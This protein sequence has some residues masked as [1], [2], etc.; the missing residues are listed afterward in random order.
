[1]NQ[2]PKISVIVPIYKAEK[3]LNRCIDSLL[4]QTFS[5]FELLLIDDGSPDK[6]GDICDVYAE[7]DSRVR[8][9]HKKNGGVS[10]ARQCGLDNAIGEYV[11]HADPDD[12]VEKDMLASM[13]SKAT[14][15]NSDIVICDF[16]M[17]MARSTKYIHVNIS[18]NNHK[19][20]L[21]EILSD[22]LHAALWNKLIRREL[23]HRYN[24]SFP[25][26]MNLWEDKFVCTSLFMNDVKVAYLP[27]AYYHYDNCS[28]SNS[29][30]RNVSKNSI[31][32]QIYYITHFE[33]LLNDIKYE[34]L[35]RD[36]K[37][38]VKDRAFVC[39]DLSYND[40]INIFPDVNSN[41]KK[42]FKLFSC[43]FY[44]NLALLI[45]NMEFPRMLYTLQNKI[46][47]TV[48]RIVLC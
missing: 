37:L 13:Y 28:N 25:I 17:D 36:M 41:F 20:L 23:Y 43:R 16:Y 35:F 7:K 29:I 44:A 10:S 24:I 45:H 32:S 26:E 31:D 39:G 22:K 18:S 15:D 8:V 6:S 34:S 42:S 2:S 48:N 9:F 30:V 27:I 4:A 47:H 1:M 11:I 3:Y 33:G 46:L 40:F 38:M 12:W 5:D 14:Y 19:I 21:Q